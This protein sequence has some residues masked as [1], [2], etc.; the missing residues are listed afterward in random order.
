M[1]ESRMTESRM[2]WSRHA[3]ERLPVWVLAG[4]TIIFFVFML[5]PILIV[6]WM[7]FSAQSFIGFPISAYSLR[8]FHRIV[9]YEPFLN[10]LIVSLE[11]GLLSTVFA[12]ILGVPAALALARSRGGFADGIAAFMLSPISMPMI[13][14]GFALLFFLS[15]IGFGIS[16]TS[17]LVAHTLVGIPYL[18]RTVIGVYRTQ[19]ADFE[20]AAAILGASRWQVFRHVTL[21]LVRPGIFAGALFAFLISLDNLP[22]SFFFGSPTT[23]T[24]PVV[25]L[26]Y[27]ENQFDP[28]I[29]AV[30]TVQMVLALAALLIVDRLYGIGHLGAPS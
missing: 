20:E 27:T 9:E 29:A 8:W 26:S 18:V 14:L 5:A 13:V 6:V 7:S 15:A 23:S 21:P 2:T 17:L 22:I 11:V 3:S 1:T 19:P 10:S 25:L 30:S 16:L 12:A 24:L 4:F 28:S